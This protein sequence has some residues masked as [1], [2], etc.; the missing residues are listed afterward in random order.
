MN[1]TESSFGARSARLLARHGETLTLV[2]IALTLGLAALPG[3]R[4][5]Y[6]YDDRRM[7]DHPFM[8]DPSDIGAVFT[9]NSV[10]YLHPRPSLEHV[11]AYTYRPIPMLTLVTAEVFAHSARVHHAVSFWLQIATVLVIYAAMTKL[12]ARRTVA[13]AATA[14]FA[15]APALTEAWV[16]INGRADLLAGLFVAGFALALASLRAGGSRWLGALSAL[17]CAALAMLS[18]ETALVALVGV[19]FVVLATRTGRESPRKLLAWVGLASIVASFGLYA[20]L[21]HLSGRQYDGAVGSSAH[22]DLRELLER[23]P[24]LV[25]L[26]VGTLLAPAARPMRILAFEFTRPLG[27]IDLVGALGFVVP[28]FVAIARRSLA[29]VVAPLFLAATLVPTGFVAD[30][31]WLGF[32]RYLYLAALPLLFAIPDLTRNPARPRL[33]W[34]V[35]M[36]WAAHLVVSIAQLHGQA[37]TFADQETFARAMMRSRPTDPTGWL[38]LAMHQGVR[39]DAEQMNA[40]LA[41]CPEA[42]ELVPQELA[43]IG[44]LFRIQQGEQAFGRIDALLARHPDD[45]RVYPMAINRLLLLSRID[46]AFALAERSR[47]DAQGCVDVK[48]S[49]RG[50]LAFPGLN[51]DI[52][53]HIEAFLQLPCAGE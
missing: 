9:R 24:R 37:K 10:D 32:D 5:D 16:F 53:Q 22:L 46:D 45:V 7:I 19:L 20:A 36:I 28:I 18:K 42:P 6:V 40:T 35:S 3:L 2:A 4:G 48:N 50:V 27:P 12:G 33:A 1:D 29:G 17:L 23:A 52:A 11:G 8:D 15:L 43:R 14:S 21:H 47:R 26:G 44:M 39:G 13:L 38:L 49:L 31:F 34:L 41:S 51:R 30:S 25:T